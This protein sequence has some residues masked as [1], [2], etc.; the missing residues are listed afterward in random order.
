MAE[1]RTVPVHDGRL[2]MTVV[3]FACPGDELP[4]H[5][6]GENEAHYSIV[7]RGCVQV[8]GP[9]W[10]RTHHAGDVFRF[11]PGERHRIVAVEHESRVV[12]VRYGEVKA[13]AAPAAWPDNFVF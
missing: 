1:A 5:E 13:S 4:W 6:H 8:F 9:G 7:A 12:N 3:D 11:K 10:Q 2:H